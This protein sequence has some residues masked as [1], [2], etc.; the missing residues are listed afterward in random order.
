MSLG[1]LPIQYADYAVWQREWMQGQVLSR[2]LDYWTRQLAGLQPLELPTDRPRRASANSRGAKQVF[3]LPNALVDKLRD[4]GRR[5]GATLFMTLLAAFQLLLKRYTGQD[6]VVVGSPVAGRTRPETEGLIGFFV[7]MLVLRSQLSGNPTFRE[8]LAR[9]R[10]TALAAYEHQD[11][12]FEK[13]VEELNP[14]RGQ[15]ETPLFQVAFAVQN[16]PR[17]KLEMPG[18]SVMPLE[19]ESSIAK[20]DL[21]VAFIEDESRST[22]RFEYRAELFSSTTMARMFQHFQR[23]LEAIV[24]DGD[25]HIGD[26]EMFSAAERQQILVEW[27]DTKQEYPAQRCMHQLFEAQVERTPDAVAVMFEGQQLTYQELN[28]RANQLAH[29]LKRLGVGTNLPVGICME[30][31]LQMVVALIG[32][33][34][35][36]RAYLPMD[37]KYPKDRI[38]FMLGDSGAR[39]LLT[40]ESLINGLPQ[41]AGSKVSLDQFSDLLANESLENLDHQGN[42]RAL[43]YVIYTSGSTGKPKGV[44]IEHRN[45]VAFLSWA[46]RA[47]TRDDFA[48]LVA[49]TSICFDLSVFELFAPLTCG[50]RVILIENALAIGSL[51]PGVPTL[52]NT[53]PSVMAEILRLGEFPPSVRTV[54]LAGEPLKSSLVD[55]IYQKTSVQQVYD[56]YGPSETTTYSTYAHRAIQSIQSIGRPIA[57]TEIYILD[58]HLNPVAVGVSGELYIGGSGVARGYLN[59]PELTTEKFI[60]NPFSPEVEARLYRTGDLARYLPD[61]NIE[62]IGRADDQVKI[63]GFRIE[64]GEIEAALHQQQAVGECVVLAREDSPGEK[65]LAAYLVAQP[66]SMMAADDLRLSL[67]RSLPEHMIPAAFV[68]MEALPLTPNGKVDRKALPRPQSATGTEGKRYRPASTETE[69]KLAEIWAEILKVDRV[70]IDDNFFDIGG[71]SL[72][73]IQVISR[74][75]EIFSVDVGVAQLFEA[76]TVGALAQ[77]IEK[78]AVKRSDNMKSSITRAPRDRYRIKISG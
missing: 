6:D 40:Q 8:L 10:E 11:I 33:L 42:P 44:M 60:P 78:L 65:Y 24:A 54:N 16:V 38:A 2:Q 52:F 36:G 30:R 9:V 66:G 32:V 31:S 71:H 12:P 53:V 59:R 39:I 41:F 37:P 22:L 55:A 3:T 68:V 61:G 23:L 75:R 77:A 20:F 74:T 47:F 7:N 45:T 17:S 69:K 73:A 58:G 46:H 26:L 50:G 56:L 18:L 25:Q 34:K 57:N 48:G 29:Y 28:Q 4:T 70:G 13:L 35:A 51:D 63:R 5:E 14:G 67:R 76:P 19:I 62:F 1:E 27:N 21:L 43:A 64:L 72:L 49:S 15:G